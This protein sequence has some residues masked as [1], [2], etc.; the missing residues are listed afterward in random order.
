MATKKAA[1]KKAPAKKAPAQRA[2]SSSTAPRHKTSV[3]KSGETVTASCS[4]GWE[5]EGDAKTAGSAAAVHA[6]QSRFRS[7]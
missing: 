1:A 6:G 3:T 7:Q 4:C 5:L 2:A